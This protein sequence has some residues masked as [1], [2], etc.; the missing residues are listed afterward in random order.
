VL[1]AHTTDLSDDDDPAFEHAVALCSTQ[2]ARLAS[3]HACVGPAPEREIPSA[4]A[5]LS[6]WGLSERR[7]DH[8]R[9]MHECCD[10]VT[11]TLLDALA[12]LAPQLVVC[13]T[14][15]RAG[16]DRL[17]AQSI[18][19]GVARNTNAATLLLPLGGRRFVDSKTGAIELGRVLVPAGDA[20]EAQQA[21]DAAARLAALAEVEAVE[22]V[23]LHV[24][25]GRPAPRPE[26]RPRLRVSYRSATGPLDEAILEAAAALDPAL[27]VMVTHGHD[28]VGDVLF[29][30]HTE[31]V[32]HQCQRPLL[33]VPY[34]P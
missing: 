10:D 26:P 17:L 2:A 8:E 3:V 6:R 13:A 19:E 14:H 5:L 20:R 18:A 31:R 28:G 32:L 29:G 15:A 7:I 9:I 25:D 21:L 16:F 27:V 34:S 30:S 23:V 12:K 1:I 33:W 22:A 4:A 11:D 24:A